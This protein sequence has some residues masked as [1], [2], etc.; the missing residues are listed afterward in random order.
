MNLV[1]RLVRLVAGCSHSDTYRERRPLHGALV[2]HLV[3]LDCGHAVPAI[4]R[5]AEE[6]H[7]A[8][9]TG[10]IR[11]PKARKQVFELARRA[12]RTA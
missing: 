6:H 5:T 11:T 2:M 12:R 1:S 10:A 4:H 3:C 7:E 8:I 9:L